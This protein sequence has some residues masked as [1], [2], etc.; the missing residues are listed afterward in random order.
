MRADM[1]AASGR[2]GNFWPPPVLT[3]YQVGEMLPH[4]VISRSF[5]VIFVLHTRVYNVYTCT[6]ILKI[7]AL[8]IDVLH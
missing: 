8:Y 5:L 2:L 6:C 4:T 3:G 7:D 1:R